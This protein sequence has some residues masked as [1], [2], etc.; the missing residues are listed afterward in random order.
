MGHREEAQGRVAAVCISRERGTQKTPVKEALLREDWG[1]EGDAHAGNWHRQVSLLSLER[2]E[3]FRARGAEV[4]FG[5]FGEN[6]AVSG[7]D[8]KAYPEGTRFR[9]GDALLEL[10]QVGKECHSHCEIYKVMQDCIM[11]REGVF[12]R[13]L[14]GG[15]VRPGDPVN[16]LYT[17]A[18][19]TVSDKGS[20]GERPDTSGPAVCAMLESEGYTVRHTA[21]IPD[22]RETIKNELLRCADELGCTLIVTTGGTGFSQRTLRRRPRWT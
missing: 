21:V 12:A 6:L 4:P 9:I 1:I 14:H 8:F 18:V 19:I 5:A 17:A 11:P 7:F 22:D 13:V 15:K 2:I 20:R 16:V 10:T 3:E